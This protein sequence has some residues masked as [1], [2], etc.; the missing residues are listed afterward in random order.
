MSRLF[1]PAAIEPQT[2]LVDKNIGA[3]PSNKLFAGTDAMK[4]PTAGIDQSP[5]T[6]APKGLLTAGIATPVVA[7]M[8]RRL[9]GI[10]CRQAEALRER[11]W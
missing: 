9:F 1:W 3:V 2:L 11:R 6:K 5:K 10:P 7:G 8:A 4:P